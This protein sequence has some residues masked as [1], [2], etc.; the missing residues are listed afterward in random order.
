MVSESNKVEEALSTLNPDVVGMS[1]SPEELE[2]LKVK[3]DYSLYESD[4]A[5]TQRIVWGDVRVLGNRIVW[6][7]L[8]MSVLAT[9]G[10]Q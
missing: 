1:V 5:W 6:G 7:D 9:S 3:E 2:A 4:A 8:S 10:I